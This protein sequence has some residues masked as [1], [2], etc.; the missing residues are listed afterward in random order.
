MLLEKVLYFYIW[1]E[2]NL[3]VWDTYVV[4]TDNFD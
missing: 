2:S 4:F 1:I 3:I